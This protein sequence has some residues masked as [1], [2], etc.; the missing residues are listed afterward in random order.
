MNN[1]AIVILNWNGKE[2]LEK[3][4]PSVIKNSEGARIIVADNASS[5]DSIKTLRTNFPGV[6]I[7]E[8]ESNGGFA[9]GYNDALKKVDA[10]LYLLLNSDVEVTDGWLIPLMDTMSDTNVAAVQPKIRA[11]N[12]KTHFEHAGACGGFIDKDYFPFCRGR[13]FENVE[14][15]N[16]QYDSSIEVFWTSGAA[17]LIRSDVFHKVGGFDEAFFAHMEE[18]DLCWRIKKMGYKLMV[19]PKSVVYHVGGA[20][21]SY[22]SPRKV[23]LNFKNNLMM[24]YK[25]HE[26]F[27]FGKVFWRKS[28]DGIAAMRFL[29]GGEF[30]AFWAVFRAHMWVYGNLRTLLKKRKEVKA[31]SNQFNAH[32]I[33]TKS[34]VWHHYAK[35]IMRFNQLDISF[36][37]K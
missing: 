2:L 27:L 1:V 29:L 23:Y 4:L 36:F 16:G 12:D 25:N 24:I 10:P 6:E 13:L 32:G 19:E 17:M 7:V 26:G 21:L 9:K 33:F 14:E 37:K 5:D 30:K 20:T 18:I 35:K 15:D 28:L 3:F 34:I 22:A 11:Y 31:Q 8:N